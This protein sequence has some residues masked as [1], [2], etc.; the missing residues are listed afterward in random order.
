MAHKK[1]NH[2]FDKYKLFPIPSLPSVCQ[3]NKQSLGECLGT[4][5]SVSRWE[6][7]LREMAKQPHTPFTLKLRCAPGNTETET[8]F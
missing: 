6:L 2:M 4:L 5:E 8:V 3:R 1:E 7:T